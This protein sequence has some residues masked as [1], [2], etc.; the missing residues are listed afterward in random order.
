MDEVLQPLG[1]T[2]A[3]FDVIQ[4]LFHED[5]LEHRALQERLAISSPTLTTVVDGLVARG[6]VERRISAEDARVRQLFLLPKAHAL[7]E[8]L[9]A[10]NDQF[11]GSMFAGFS[12]GESALFLDW[13]DRVADNLE[14]G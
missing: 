1:V 5:G 12:A 9:G 2:A 4:Q 6:M 3:Q 8:Q 14:G 10:I 7:H 11:I 13:L